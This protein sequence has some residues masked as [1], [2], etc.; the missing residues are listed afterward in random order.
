MKSLLKKLSIT[1]KHLVILDNT[2]RNKNN[3][4]RKI[5]FSIYDENLRRFEKLAF[6]TS[7]KAANFRISNQD[8][9]KVSVSFIDEIYHQ[10]ERQMKLADIIEYLFF[11]RGIYYLF[12]GNHFKKDR[13]PVFLEL[14]LRFVNL[15]MICEV[16]TVDSKLRKKLL[17]NLKG[18]IGDEYGFSALYKWKDNVGLQKNKRKKN[19]PFEYF[20]TLL[21]KTA[22]GLWHEMLV[23]AFVLKYDIGYIF[24]LLINQKLISSDSKLSPP[25]L[26]VLHKKT[27]RYYG[28]EIG[29]LKD[30]QSGGFMS[31][32][33]IPVIPVD[34]LNAR[35]SDRCPHC[36]RWIGICPKVISDFASID[37]QKPENEIRCFVDCDIFS[38]KD[39][40]SGKCPYMKFSY[41]GK[42]NNIKFTFA[43]KKHYHYNCCLE[44]KAQLKKAIEGHKDFK[45]L[46]EY[47]SN[48]EN[49]G[50]YD[51]L[52]QKFNF[53]KTHS[54]F[55]SE[56]TKLIS[57]NKM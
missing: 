8:K 26:I 44:I 37:K 15:L 5:D 34:T 50:L 20:D 48:K 10:N 28:I 47:H 41:N 16:V 23:Y 33:G 7:L 56:L 49:N 54:V 18:I 21:P 52:K 12:Q 38:L 6:K 30:R 51:K 13:I 31:P 36:E 4:S 40:V 55:Y 39:M 32:S 43:D 35:I 27:M 25:D 53:I 45:K 1:S 14:I 9:Q 17:N 19:E 22:G 57:M 46:Q 24:S 42:I 29:N 11:S 3:Y 2:F